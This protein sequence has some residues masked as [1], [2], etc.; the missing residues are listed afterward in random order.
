MGRDAVDEVDPVEYAAQQVGS[1]DRQSD[2][3]HKSGENGPRAFAQHEPKHFVLLCADSDPDA[4]FARAKNE[5]VA[6]RTADVQILKFAA[7]SLC[8]DWLSRVSTSHFLSSPMKYGN[9]KLKNGQTTTAITSTRVM[10][11]RFD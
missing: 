11:I 7:L 5:D 6:D 1:A 8:S 3:D 10:I 4:D 2:A 9:P